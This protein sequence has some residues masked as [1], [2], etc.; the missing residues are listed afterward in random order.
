MGSRAGTAAAARR[1]GP[2]GAS[3]SRPPRWWGPATWRRCRPISRATR[4]SR[5]HPPASATTAPS[6]APTPATRLSSCLAW[7]PASPASW[8]ASY[9][10]AWACRRASPPAPARSPGPPRPPSYRDYAE[11][12]TAW[13]ATTAPHTLEAPAAPP[14]A[15]TTRPG[16][17]LKLGAIRWCTPGT[18]YSPPRSRPAPPRLRSPATRSTPTASCCRT[19]RCRTAATGWRPAGRAT[20]ASPP[21]RSCSATYGPTRPCPARRNFWP[22]TLGPQAWA[23]PL[24]RLRPPPPAICTSPR[25]PPPAAP[26][27]CLCGV[28]TLWG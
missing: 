11:T 5:C 25:P 15:H 12:P 27:R 3:R 10:G 1:P 16:P 26:G 9:R 14:A 2:P 22:P 17:V 21:R 24:R 8:E 7:I 20:S 23:A 13:E 6:W 18:R 4:C 28:H 19:N